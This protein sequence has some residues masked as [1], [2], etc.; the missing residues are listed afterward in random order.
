MEVEI[1]IKYIFMTHAKNTKTDSQKKES[2]Q[3]FCHDCGQEIKING[4]EITEGKLLVYQTDGQKI[5]IFKCDACYKKNP[6]LTN[7]RDCEV[8][9][10]I[11]GYLRPVQQWNKG[12]KQEFSERKEFV[13]K[14]CDC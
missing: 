11:V 5:E 14:S 7:Y 8:Y 4:Q 12:K 1:I 9:S 3:T 2:S 13:V 10:R 6:R